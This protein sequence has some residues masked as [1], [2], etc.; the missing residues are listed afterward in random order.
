[1]DADTNKGFPMRTFAAHASLFLL[2]AFCVHAAPARAQSAPATNPEASADAAAPAEAAPVDAVP[3][4]PAA[5]AAP[6]PAADESTAPAEG[7]AA[8]TAAETPAETP[9]E[10]AA[11]AED[12]P[13]EP[14]AAPAAESTPTTPSAL[15]GWGWLSVGGWAA[16]AVGF[17]GVVIGAV[18][19]ANPADFY[20]ATQNRQITPNSVFGFVA[21]AAGASLAVV[22]GVLLYLDTALP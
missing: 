2:V 6:A 15:R 3:L 11:P 5:D 8:A 19:L 13:S 10:E 12:T 14:E 16:L 4:D 20:A 7:D 17:L 1:M 22:G 21:L 18:T 9:A